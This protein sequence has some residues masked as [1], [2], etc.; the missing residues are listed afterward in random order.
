MTEINNKHAKKI[1]TVLLL[2]AVIVFGWFSVEQ[3][4]GQEMIEKVMEETLEARVIEIIK[5]EEIVDE[6][7]TYEYQNLELLV[8]K[9]SLTGKKIYVENGDVAL[10]NSKK[11]EVG[12]RLLVTFTKDADGVD[13]F[14][15]MDYYRADSILKLFIIFVILA[16]LVAGWKGASSVVGMGLSFV[17]IFKFIIPRILDGADPIFVSVLGACLIIPVSFYMSH[18]FSKKTTVAIVG[19]IISLILTGV[20][21]GVFV[22][23]LK[24]SGFASEEAGFLS[25][26][27]GGNIN[28]KGILLAGMVVSA[29]GILDDITISQAS[30]AY[31]LKKANPELGWVELNKEAMEVGRDHIASMVNSLVLVYAGA[32]LPLLLL[33][34]NN[35]HPFSEIINYEIVADEIVRTLVGSIGLILAVPITT[36]IASMVLSGEKE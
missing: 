7:G 11:Y 21:A 22:D 20:L 13:F 3:V 19:T 14:Y 16:V 4:S 31:Q 1:K 12:D 18:G 30:I 17:V 24:I 10:A 25:V 26:E 27:M 6:Y 2:I 28:M 34:V 36:V 32:S 9:G 33:F 35:P 23:V 29:L 5:E 15:I 8:T